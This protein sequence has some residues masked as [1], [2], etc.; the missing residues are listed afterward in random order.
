[1]DQI[2][3][4]FPL[5]CHIVQSA[6]I[7]IQPNVVADQQ[8][9]FAPLWQLCSRTGA[10]PART[11]K[12]LLYTDCFQDVPCCQTT[13]IPNHWLHWLHSLPSTESS[14]RDMWEHDFSSRSFWNAVLH[15]FSAWDV[16]PKGRPRAQTSPPPQCQ[17]Q[18]PRVQLL[19]ELP[20]CP[21]HQF[22][23]LV[24]SYKLTTKEIR[25]LPRKDTKPTHY[26]KWNC[27]CIDPYP[28]PTHYWNKC[29][30]KTTLTN[31]KWTRARHTITEKKLS[32]K[33]KTDTN[34]S[35]SSGTVTKWLAQSWKIY[36]LY[37]PKVT[38]GVVKAKYWERNL[39]A[40][41]LNT[42]GKCCPLCLGCQL[43]CFVRHIQNY[44]HAP[45]AFFRRNS[46][47]KTTPAPSTFDTRRLLH[48]NNFC[49]KQLLHQ[50]A[51]IYT[52]QLWHQ[53]EQFPG[54][55]MQKCWKDHACT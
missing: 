49:T 11:E 37:I 23:S 5:H 7:H 17:S 21:C 27:P 20:N 55:D 28:C 30:R 31:M 51:F 44:M 1:M 54:S 38:R 13:S 45:H 39:M 2:S 48:Q 15:F 32:E 24:I 6:R 12:N 50:K 14:Y 25:V 33:I 36:S 42:Q 9:C 52:K 29:L 35:G 53:N 41:C 19:L 34:I 18:A 46:N 10:A 16:K 22:V 4:C 8:L 47:T 43:L 40:A 26:M 3:D